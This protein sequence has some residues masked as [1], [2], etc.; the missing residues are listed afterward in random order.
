MYNND[1]YSLWEQR[2]T[3]CESSGQSISAWC[4]EHS[5]K[6]NQFYY[7]RKKLRLRQVQNNNPVKWLPLKVEQPSCGL[8]SIAVHIGQVTVEIRK[9]FDQNLFREIVQVL[10]TI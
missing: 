9:G 10:Q 5:I 3:E 7:W 6:V 1:L 2:L 4:K 8:N